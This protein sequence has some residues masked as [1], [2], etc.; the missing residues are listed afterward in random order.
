VA[1]LY[2]LSVKDLLTHN[3]GLVDLTVPADLDHDPPAVMLAALAERTGV[4]PAQLKAMT[5]AGW[6]PWLFDTLWM[7]Q[8]DAQ[9]SFDIYVRGN[10][11]LLAPGEAGTNQVSRWRTWGGPWFPVR[12]LNRVC[13]ACAADPNRGKA[14]V[15]RLPLMIGCVEHRCRLEDTPDI[16]LSVALDGERP[17]PT[18]VDEPLATLDR[19]THEAL[20]TGQVPLPGRTVHVGVWFRLLRSLLD[21]VSLA[22]T[23]RSTHG[24]ATLEQ[25][26][27][28]TSRPERAGLTSWRPYEQLDWTMQEAMLHAAATA[29]QLVASGRITARG[30]LGSALKPAPYRHVYDG[31]QPSPHGPSPHHNAWQ[32]AMA[33]VEAAITLARTDR[34]T[35]R[36]LLALLTIGC[37]TLDRFEEERAYLFDIGIPATSFPAPAT[38]AASTSPDAA[39]HI[40]GST[41]PPA[42]TAN[43]SAERPKN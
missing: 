34:D 5:L 2:N 23:T 28:A 9:A 15:W 36:Q 22:L 32:E 33:E 27:Q 42:E 18:P 12:W 17:Q 13:P 3:L 19:Y 30:T 31:D 14:L 40:H 24:R 10:S 43:P 26:W 35:A 39:S 1:G 20:T 11:V 8:H 41:H 7:R 4:E 6:V 25:I 21:E 16:T 37:R 29:L 38:S